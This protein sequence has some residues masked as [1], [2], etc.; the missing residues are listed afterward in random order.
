MKNRKHRN[1]KLFT[2]TYQ[3]SFRTASGKERKTPKR[4]Y[5][6]VA[7]SRG[8]FLRGFYFGIDRTNTQIFSI[9]ENPV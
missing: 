4:T 3:T 5:S 9:A 2:V 7:D 1:N 8:G 6:N